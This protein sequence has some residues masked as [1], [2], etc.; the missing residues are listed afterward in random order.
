M[1][2]NAFEDFKS[3]FISIDLSTMSDIITRTD[4]NKMKYKLELHM[5]TTTFNFLYRPD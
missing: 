3:K 5:N 2:L 1:I 4:K